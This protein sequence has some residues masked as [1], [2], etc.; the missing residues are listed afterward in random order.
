MVTIFS[1]DT[2]KN[3]GEK[4]NVYNFEFDL[5]SEEGTC[6]LQTEENKLINQENIK[7][8]KLTQEQIKI[9]KELNE[10]TQHETFSST[11]E[12]FGI[13]E[14]EQTIVGGSSQQHSSQH[15]KYT[16]S[17]ASEHTSQHLSQFSPQHTTQSSIAEHS[18]IKAI[19]MFQQQQQMLEQISQQ[20]DIQKHTS[21]LQNI[22]KHHS[23]LPQQNIPPTPLTSQQN[24]PQHPLKHSSVSETSHTLKH[25]QTSGQHLNVGKFDRLPK[26]EIL[27]IIKHRENLKTKETKTKTPQTFDYSNLNQL[28]LKKRKQT[29]I[30][31]KL[32]KKIKMS[33]SF[34]NRGKILDIIF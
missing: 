10:L 28:T 12:P 5:G 21:T 15:I 30:E 27:K 16:S 23:T 17:H 18:N 3:D 9:Y 29:R 6:S 33:P 31:N 14:S 1:C 2:A 20:M 32:N 11:T 24:I 22:P 19:E 26:G 13:N 34:Q 7:E 25:P 8:N 4:E